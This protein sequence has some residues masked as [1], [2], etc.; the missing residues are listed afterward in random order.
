MWFLMALWG[1]LTWLLVEVVVFLV[2]LPLYVVGLPLAWAAGR[3]AK[4]VPATSI[5]DSGRLITAYTNPLLDWWVGNYEDGVQPPGYT[6]FAWF[7]R[8]PVC[9][10]RFAPVISTLPSLDT[11][12]VGNVNE[13]PPDGTPGW[14]LAWAHGYV[15]FRWQCASWGVWAGWKL[16]PADASGPCTD[17]RRFGLGTAAQILRF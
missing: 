5:C 3:W 17:Y 11:R 7:V 15:G 2:F 9:N 1:L 13:I 10:L 6:A 8:N 12:W 16:N 14:F 4:T